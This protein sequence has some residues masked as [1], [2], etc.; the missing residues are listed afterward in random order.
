MSTQL[1]EDNLKLLESGTLSD[2]EIRCKKRVWK[3]HK[4]I[5]CSGSTWFEE[6]V[7][8]NEKESQDGKIKITRMDPDTM[9][10]VLKYIYSGEVILK[11]PMSIG[12]RLESF[13]RLWKHGNFFQ[14]DQ[15]KEKALELLRGNFVANACWQWTYDTHGTKYETCDIAKLNQDLFHAVQ[16]AYYRNPTARLV[17]KTLAAC[18]YAMGTDIDNV[19]LASMRATYSQFNIDLMAVLAGVRFD[20]RFSVVY[21][22]DGLVEAVDEEVLD[23]RWECP[24]C[25][26]SSYMP[27]VTGDPFSQG[28]HKWCLGCA[29]GALVSRVQHVVSLM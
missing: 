17:Q 4:S 28:K 26:E 16:L 13:V 8:D 22:P 18:V 12:F 6:A 19:R 29:K 23:R 9:D 5:L 11:T 20:P 27:Q 21:G 14:L 2:I 10:I 15:V 1:G 25:E 24:R 7:A 3:A